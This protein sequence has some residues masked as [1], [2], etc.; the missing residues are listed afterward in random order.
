MAVMGG[1]EG[2]GHVG[3]SSRGSS[4]MSGQRR[5]W[6]LPSV[7]AA[8]AFVG[9]GLALLILGTLLALLVDAH[10]AWFNEFDLGPTD[11]FRQL[12]LSMTPLAGAA[13]WLS[14]VGSRRFNV[15][16]VP[17]VVIALLVIRQWRWAVFLLVVSQGGLLVG[18]LTKRLVARERPPWDDFDTSQIG[19]SFPSGHTFTGITIWV[20]IGVVAIFVLPRPWSTVVA[21]VP[22]AI[23]VLNGPSRLVL[24]QHWLTD[25]LGAWLLG[26]GWLLLVW[27]M[28]LA[29][30]A[31]RRAG[32]AE[33]PPAE[34]PPDAETS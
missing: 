30:L 16:V 25:V 2:E 29:L 28:F 24:A 32:V 6:S 13:E 14:T 23:G 19:A 17:V 33:Q 3:G 21:T 12:G 11:W 10:E 31:P 9:I 4:R 1:V 26:V 20:A 15:I 7:H 8:P 27:G 5:Y 34:E 22:V 18:N